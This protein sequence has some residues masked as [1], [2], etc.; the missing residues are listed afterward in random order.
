MESNLTNEEMKE[1]TAKAIAKAPTTVDMA[2][3]NSGSRRNFILIG[4]GDGGCNIANAIHSRDVFYRIQY[5]K[6]D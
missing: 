6:C 5:H 2:I 3:K 1:L 4:T